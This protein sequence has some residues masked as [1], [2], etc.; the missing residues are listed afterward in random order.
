MGKCLMCCGCSILLTNVDTPVKMNPAL[1]AAITWWRRF[2]A[3]EDMTLTENSEEFTRQNEDVVEVIETEE[4]AEVINLSNTTVGTVRAELVRMNMSG[5]EKIIATEIEVKQGGAVKLQ[6]QDIRL[7][8]GGALSIEGETVILNNGFAGIVRA[9]EASLTDCGAGIV[10]AEQTSLQNV[11]SGLLVAGEVTSETV[12]AT[13]FL[14]G[15][16]EGNVETVLDTPRAMLAGLTAGVA[17][18]LVLFIG[19]LLTRRKSL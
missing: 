13:I 5:A 18:G 8:Q 14:A 10:V 2:F 3:E 16:V 9:E 1:V 17:V 11:Q 15:N 7:S 19:Q 12:K 6:A 4:S